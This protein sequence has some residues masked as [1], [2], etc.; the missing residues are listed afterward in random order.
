MTDE[1][2]FLLECRVNGQAVRVNVPPMARLLDVLRQ[3]LCL[4]GTKEGCGEGECGACAV[5]MDGALVNSCLVPVIQAGGADILTV[6]G[7]VVGEAARLSTGKSSIPCHCESLHPLQK[8]FH[9]LNGAQCGFCTPGFLMAAKALLDRRP[10]PDLAE[11]KEGLSGN[12][13]RCTGYAKILDS[14]RAAGE[15]EK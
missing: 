5:I 15:G 11:M 3:N 13:C 9:E 10:C 12:L 4:T 1:N 8:A 2:A 6:E 14:V 7:L